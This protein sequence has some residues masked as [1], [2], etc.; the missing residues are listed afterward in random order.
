MTTPLTRAQS[1]LVARSVDKIE[2]VARGLAR[3]LH[4]VSEEDLI[5]VG[6]EVLVT[7]VTRYDPETGVPFEKYAAIR[8]R[9]AMI[10][11]ARKWSPGYRCNQRALRALEG[12]RAVLEQ[13]A[14]EKLP[15]RA[16]LEARVKMAEQLVERT[17]VALLMARA[18]PTEPDEVG[19]DELDQETRLLDDE[20]R[21][22]M[23]AAV[24]ALEPGERSLISAIYFEGVSMHAVAESESKHVSTISRRHA[25][26]VA[27][28]ASQLTQD[29]RGEFSHSLAS[30]RDSDCVSPPPGTHA[31]RVAAET[32]VRPR[33]RGPDR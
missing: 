4:S 9:G 24:D 33:P 7:A 32:R 8:A 13:A 17:S 2:Q 14:R 28:L 5:S 22:R 3:H 29:D 26:I 15:D 16:Q 1:E 31:A 20:S 25:K 30:G 6:N 19:R 18:A 21:R 11:W 12:S 23:L 27:K 10:D